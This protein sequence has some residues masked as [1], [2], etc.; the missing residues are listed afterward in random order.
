MLGVAYSCFHGFMNFVDS[1][2]PSVTKSFIDKSLNK[3]VKK[4]FG[5]R[6]FKLA[7]SLKKS[8]EFVNIAKLLSSIS[9]LEMFVV[10]LNMEIFCLITFAFAHCHAAH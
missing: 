7:R 9:S 3:L 5:T 4:C 1:K 2:F 6:F 10:C 8:I